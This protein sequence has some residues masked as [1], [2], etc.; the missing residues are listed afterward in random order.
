MTESRG[1][2]I[3]TDNRQMKD[4]SL[5]DSLTKAMIRKIYHR[6]LGDILK[7]VKDYQYR[8]LDKDTRQGGDYIYRILGRKPR[9]SN[10]HRLG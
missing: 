5:G 3:I 6:L 1:E 8:I 10:R 7:R 4:D 2:T 9:K